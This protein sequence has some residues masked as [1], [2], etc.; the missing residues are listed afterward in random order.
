M[1]RPVWFVFGG[2]GSQWPGMASDL[3]KIPCFADSVERCSKYIKPIGYDIVD[4]ITNPDPEI[5]KSK[6]LV[7]FLAISTIHVNKT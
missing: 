3:M 6:P 4:I 5:L 1:N 7:S 2:M